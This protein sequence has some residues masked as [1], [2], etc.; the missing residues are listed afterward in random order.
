MLCCYRMASVCSPCFVSCAQYQAQRSIEKGRRKYMFRTYSTI[1]SFNKLH[2]FF[3]FRTYSVLIWH[4]LAFCIGLEVKFSLHK[5]CYIRYSASS[6]PHNA[7]SP[8]VAGKTS[9]RFYSFSSASLSHSHAKGM[10]LLAGARHRVTLTMRWGVHTR[11]VSLPGPRHLPEQ[12]RQQ[13]G[14]RI[15]SSV[16]ALIE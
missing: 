7:A 5:I 4:V 6:T 1:A 8:T 14:L 9:Q 12:L 2:L 11:C 3:L 16:L 15:I 13:V 10:A